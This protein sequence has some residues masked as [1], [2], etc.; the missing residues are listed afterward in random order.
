LSALQ[1]GGFRVPQTVPLNRIPRWISRRVAPLIWVRPRFTDRCE[2]CGKCARACPAGALTAAP[3]L[4]PRL[5][6]RR[7]IA[8]CCCHEVCPAKAIEMRPSPLLWIAR[9]G[10]AF[11]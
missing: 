1:S 4:K 5:D 7:C 6:S 11:R 2:Y 10:R 3:Q 9:R 8:C